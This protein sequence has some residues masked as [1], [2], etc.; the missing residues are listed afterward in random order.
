M[1]GLLKSHCL[2]ANQVEV[3]F[4]RHFQQFAGSIGG[5]GKGSQCC[6]DDYACQV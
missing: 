2:F 3:K 6:F 5:L 1:I 4:K